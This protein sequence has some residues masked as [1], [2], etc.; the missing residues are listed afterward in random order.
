MT[1][2]ANPEHW[3]RLLKL[4]GRE[5]LI[6]DERLGTPDD[7]VANEAEDIRRN[8]DLLGKVY[9]LAPAQLPRDRRLPRGH[10]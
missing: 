1:S 8:V 5:D 9:G 7:R 3:D 10:R 2:R 4:V 6:G